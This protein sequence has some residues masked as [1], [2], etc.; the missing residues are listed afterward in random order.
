MS[1]TWDTV[2]EESFSSVPVC[3]KCIIICLLLLQAL[4][5]HFVCHVPVFCCFK[6]CCIHLVVYLCNVLNYLISCTPLNLI[7]VPLYS[8]QFF[9]FIEVITGIFNKRYFASL[10]CVFYLRYSS[11]WNPHRLHS[12]PFPPKEKHNV[13]LLRFDDDHRPHLLPFCAGSYIWRKE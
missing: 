2:F 8:F 6:C 7:S 13:E 9:F 4:T 1:N 11:N 10:T 3:N 5:C 12:E